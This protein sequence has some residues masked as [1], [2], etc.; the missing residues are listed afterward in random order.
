VAGWPVYGGDSGGSRYSPATQIDRSNVTALRVAW[1]FRTG[2]DFRC[3]FCDRK[4][5]EATPILVEGKLIFS[6]PSNRVFALDPETGRELW[7]YDPRIDYSHGYSEYTSRGVSAWL[8]EQAAPGSPCRLRI[9]EGTVDGRLI[10]L[11]GAT[12]APCD[13]FGARGQLDLTQSVGR[14]QSGQYQVTSPPAIL[15]DLVIVGSAIGDNRAVEL[16]RG[17]VR[18][19]DARTGALRWSWDPIPRDP[20]D[21]ARA[22]WEGAGADRAGAANAWSILSVD[23]DRDL[24]FVPTTSPSPDFYGGERLGDN[25]YAD[26][27]VALRGSTGQVVWHYQLVHHD[28]WDYDLPAQPMLLTLRRDGRDVP[29]VVQATKMGLLFVLDR[30]TGQPLIPVEER[31]VPQTDVPGERTSPTQPFPTAPPPLV[32]HKLTAAEAWGLT[33]WDRKACREQLEKLRSEG[34]YTPPSLRGTVVYPGFAGGTNWGSA[35]F[36]PGRGLLLVNSSRLAFF[37]QLVPSEQFAR[38]DRSDQAEWALQRGAPYAMRRNPLLSPLRL[39]CSPPPWGTLAAVDLAQGTIRWEVPLGTVRDLAKIPLPIR[40]GTPNLGGP[41]VT[42]SGLVFVGAAMDHYLRAFDVETGREL[43]K[44]RLPAG[45]QATPMT[46]Q[47]SENGKQY[48]VIA[49]GGHG[50]AGTKLGDSLVAYALRDR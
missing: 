22:T 6:T 39:P 28:L 24:V 37:V 13:G 46:Y 3:R 29:A 20:S 38:R 12:G 26:S 5:F 47:M 10:A 30:D 34:I 50:K 11:D 40:W 33:P 1:T 49:A 36:D 32:P 27:V 21:P 18:A 14:V 19:F 16:E 2:E 4:A 42:A 23:T 41:L 31:P 35:A 8:D 15:R 25:R 17:V 45:G 7:R 43:W 48:V 44:G 9:Y